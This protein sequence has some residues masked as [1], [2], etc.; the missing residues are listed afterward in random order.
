MHRLMN[1]SI[2]SIIFLVL[3]LRA[4]R[5]D[6]ITERQVENPFI[7]PKME[8]EPIVYIKV[9]N[10]Y[11]QPMLNGNFDLVETRPDGRR[12]LHICGGH[13]LFTIN[14]TNYYV[15]KTNFHGNHERMF[16]FTPYYPIDLAKFCIHKGM[17]VMEADDS[18]A[19]NRASWMLS[20]NSIIL[21]TT[22]N[23]LTWECKTTWQNNARAWFSFEPLNNG[24]SN[25]IAPFICKAI[26]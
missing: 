22:E 17:F 13:V 25:S 14:E 9:G 10:K 26:K 23:Q 5:L 15:W 19:L 1:R 11:I 7:A 18:G 2:A 6:R 3:C 20:T 21:S 8:S 24:G 12:G 16:L 4:Y